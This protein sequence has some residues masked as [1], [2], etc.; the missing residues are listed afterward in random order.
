VTRLSTD[1]RLDVHHLG[2]LGIRADHFGEVNGPDV[3]LDTALCLLASSLVGEVISNPVRAINEIETVNDVWNFTNEGLLAIALTHVEMFVHEKLVETERLLGIER[4]LTTAELYSMDAVERAKLE[5]EL[6]QK[7]HEDAQIAAE[8]EQAR[9][10]AEHRAANPGALPL[11]KTHD[12]RVV[13]GKGYK[14]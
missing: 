11:T 4:Q 8:A 12:G 3:V 9:S 6:V 5:P 2:K 1:V 10:V 7:I 14:V 13:H